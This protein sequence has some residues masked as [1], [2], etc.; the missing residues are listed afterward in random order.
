MKQNT[1]GYVIAAIVLGAILSC[2]GCLSGS[3]SSTYHFGQIQI[4]NAPNNMYDPGTG[5]L[6][7]EGSVKINVQTPS[8]LNEFRTIYGGTFGDGFYQI[9]RLSD[10]TTIEGR[11]LQVYETINDA[12]SGNGVVVIVGYC[13][14]IPFDEKYSYGRISQKNGYIGIET[15]GINFN[16]FLAIAKSARVV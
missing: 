4:D 7:K 8:S 3:N 15:E 5:W 16:D 11:P 9:K 13:G 2:S 14:F 1:M 12:A 6:A 10:D